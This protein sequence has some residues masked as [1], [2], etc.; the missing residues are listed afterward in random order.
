MQSWGSN[1]IVSLGYSQLGFSA[2]P[3][4]GM[5]KVPFLRE[6]ERIL[7]GRPIDTQN[8]IEVIDLMLK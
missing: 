2:T 1:E 7:A 6:A 8:S 3:R 5:M 4:C